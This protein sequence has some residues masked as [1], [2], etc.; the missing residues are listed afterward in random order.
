MMLYGVISVKMKQVW[1]L[2]EAVPALVFGV[3][4]GRMA[5]RFLDSQRW[6]SAAEDQSSDITL[7]C[8]YSACKYT[9]L[10]KF[11]GYDTSRNRYTARHGRVPAS[12]EVS[13]HRWK[14]MTLLLI[15]M[16]TM[17]WL[18]TTGCIKLM[19][20]KLTLLTAMIS[21]VYE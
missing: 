18:C 13:R 17:M 14:D 16:M 9:C 12:H 7:V 8:Y 1:Y 21:A 20:P 4:L 15:P 2:G 6:G 3:I 19:V 11:A 5:A 10:L